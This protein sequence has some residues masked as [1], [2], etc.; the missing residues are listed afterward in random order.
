MTDK[1]WASFAK[2]PALQSLTVYGAANL[3]GEGL[4]VLQ[5]SAIHSLMV[6]CLTDKTI[7]EAATLPLHTLATGSARLTDAGLKHLVG[8]KLTLLNLKG[9]KVTAAGVKEL[10]A[11]LPACRI[12]WDQG[13]IEPTAQGKP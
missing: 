2:Y 3:R 11:R 7:E 1:C 9:A 4:S 10:S 5:D 13:T 12:M 6:R 8:T